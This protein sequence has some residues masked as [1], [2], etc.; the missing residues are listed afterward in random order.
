MCDAIFIVIDVGNLPKQSLMPYL[1]AL[2]FSGCG[3]VWKDISGQIW[4]NPVSGDTKYK[5][6]GV[7]FAFRIRSSGL[8]NGVYA[9]PF[10]LSEFWNGLQKSDYYDRET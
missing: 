5:T 9:T 8:G 2:P 4:T 3:W 1:S 7:S 10:D 6:T